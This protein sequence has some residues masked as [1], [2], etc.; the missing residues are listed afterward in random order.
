M[1]T[2]VREVAGGDSRAAADFR[3]LPARIYPPRLRVHDAAG[4]LAL[5]SGRHPLSGYLSL[6]AFVCYDGSE[7]V[8]RMALTRYP[9]DPTQYL[10]FF[11]CVDDEAVSG[12]LFGH[13]ARLGGETGATSVL[14]PV[15]A[16]FW[17]RYRL[18]VSGFDTPPFFSEPVNQPYYLR[19]FQAA[20]YR[21]CDS[22]VSNLY[23]RPPEGYRFPLFD[24]RIDEFTRRGVELRSPRRREWELT[25]RELHGLLHDLYR[26]FPVFTPI[27]YR[28]FRA[29]FA[30][31]R[32]ITDLSMVV[33]AHH[34]G[35]AVGF[36]VAMP[37]YGTRLSTGPLP[38]RVAAFVRGRRRSDRYVLLYL[39]ARAEYPGLGSALTGVVAHRIAR[40][41][42]EAVGA[43]IHEGRVTAG[44]ASGLRRAR[45]EY[46]LLRRDLG[47]EHG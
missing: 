42:A 19:L 25:M 4:E 29:V 34:H 40:R 22:Y 11:E 30:G 9:D 18:K 17:L 43:L 35:R 21:V 3:R 45:T 23:P 1:G 41:G 20:G 47:E 26:D 37:D 16:S 6:R 24:R 13:A 10:G 8:G 44:Y 46:V 7:A 14:G 38:G 5:L 2:E 32:L 28:D 27:G 33:M 12:A 15:D 36:L 31:F 39:G